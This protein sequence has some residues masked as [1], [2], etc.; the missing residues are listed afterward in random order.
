MPIRDFGFLPRG[1]I[2][3]LRSAVVENLKTTNH[4]LM[5]QGF[6]LSSSKDKVTFHTK[7]FLIT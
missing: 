1:I 2:Y 5:L 7:P 6:F 4:L 3:S